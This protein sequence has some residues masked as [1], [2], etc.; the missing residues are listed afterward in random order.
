MPKNKPGYS[1]PARREGTDPG[2]RPRNERT[3]ND[4]VHRAIGL[5]FCG[6]KDLRP[7]ASG[8]PCR[9]T[10]LPAGRKI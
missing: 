9:M 7:T 2:Y 6:K 4:A 10:Y 5:P 3:Q 8:G 1:G